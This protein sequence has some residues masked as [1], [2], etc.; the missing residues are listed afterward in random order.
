[1]KIKIL[2]SS[3]FVGQH[4]LKSLSSSDGISVRNPNWEKGIV[5]GDILINLVGKA[6]DHDG[7]AKEEDYYYANV[8]KLKEIFSAFLTSNA[9]MLIHFSS[10][11]AIEEFEAD[12]LLNEDSSSNAVSW[13][14]K[15]KFLAEKWLLEQR[16]PVDKKVVIIRPPMIHGPGDKG[17]LGLFYKFISKGLPY[18][19]SSFNNKRSFIFINN[20]VFFIKE[21]INKSTVIAGGIYHVADNEPIST[22][23]IVKVIEASIGKNNVK[24]DFP[25]FLIQ[26]LAKVG[27]IIPIPFN[28]K[29]LRKL[30]SN[31]LVSNSKIKS[32]LN[33]T[34]IPFSAIDGLKITIDSFKEEKR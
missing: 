9:K 22:S 21:I 3:G 30:T 2:G 14:G 7:T 28:T 16:I 34:S 18:P 26:W 5:D 29:R 19:L 17:N 1:M 31:L 20:L 13:Y 24:V 33:I 23:E 8:E 15:S 6:H 32:S 27:D 12:E 25:K 11:A 4:L 10:I